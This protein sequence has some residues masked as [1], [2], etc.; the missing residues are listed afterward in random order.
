MIAGRALQQRQHVVPPVAGEAA[1]VLRAGHPKVQVAL[2]VH[3]QEPA[4][5]AQVAVVAVAISPADQAALQH[6]AQHDEC[7]GGEAPVL[8]ALARQLLQLLLEQLPT[9]AAMAH[10]RL[11]PLP[12]RLRRCRHKDS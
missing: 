7:F 3:P 12:S 6:A 4:D 11:T 9:G 2:Q 8:H 10:L 5:V 1:P